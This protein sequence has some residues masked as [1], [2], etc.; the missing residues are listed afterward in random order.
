M[1]IRMDTELTRVDLPII[2]IKDHKNMKGRRV[3]TTYANNL[4]PRIAILKIPTKDTGMNRVFP[5]IPAAGETKLPALRPRIPLLPIANQKWE[6]VPHNY[7]V[8]EENIP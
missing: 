4:D 7:N 1:K 8:E 6:A 5:V 3:T 2:T